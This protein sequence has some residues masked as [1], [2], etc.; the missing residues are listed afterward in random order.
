MISLFSLIVIGASFGF[1][2]EEEFGDS[3]L[4]PN[5]TTTKNR[6]IN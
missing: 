6:V 3:I 5:L 2:G 1:G 4:N